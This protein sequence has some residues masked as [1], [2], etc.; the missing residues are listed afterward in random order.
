MM[1][2]VAAILVRL[3]DALP[4]P[5][6]T[7]VAPTHII[8]RKLAQKSAR[9]GHPGQYALTSIAPHGPPVHSPPEAVRYFPL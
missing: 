2:P 4:A 9:F 7:S 5:T 8:A 3:V 1:I 6:S